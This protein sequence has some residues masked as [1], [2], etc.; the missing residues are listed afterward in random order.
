[1][2]DKNKN[3]KVDIFLG[4]PCSENQEQKNLGAKL[5]KSS[6]EK[7]ISLLIAILSIAMMLSFV[8]DLI[9]SSSVN[10]ELAIASKDRVKSEYLVKSGFNLGV[11]LLTISKAYQNV[12]KSQMNQTIPDDLSSIWGMFNSLPPIGRDT[13]DLVKQMGGNKEED[14]FQLKGVLAEKSADQMALFE[15]QFSIKIFDESSKINLNACRSGRCKET[16]EQLKNLFSCPVEKEFLDKKGAR[17]DQLAYLIKDFINMGSTVS[18]ESGLTDFNEKYQKG[19]FPYKKKNSPFDF[20]DQLKLVYLWDDEVDTVFSPYLTVYPFPIRG[21]KAEN[22]KININTAA[23]ELLSCLLPEGKEADNQREIAEKLAKLRE[24]KM[25]LASDD[26]GITKAME[27][28]GSFSSDDDKK[29]N[30]R[31]KWFKT[32][33]SFFNIQVEGRTRDQS[34]S[35]SSVVQ[36]LP[37]GDSSHLRDKQKVK[38]AYRLLRWSQL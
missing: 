6:R 1:M 3:K 21:K 19:K 23:H 11:F 29:R 26:A 16:I 13:V 10:V 37:A 15:D 8:G 17:P 20:I 14:P 5:A 24:K 4:F 33:S 18:P 12:A 36:F 35:L 2:F 7:G 30:E 38:R 32:T 28:F 9:L 27:T 25:A 31:V 22:Y 34:L